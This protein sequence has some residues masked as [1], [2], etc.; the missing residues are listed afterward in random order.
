MGGLIFEVIRL[1]D[2]NAHL[3]HQSLRVD[4]N[5]PTTQP[6]FTYSQSIMETLKQYEKLVES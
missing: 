1:I 6:A 5:F 2:R 3:V 4:V